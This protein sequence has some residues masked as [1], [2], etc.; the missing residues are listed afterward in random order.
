MKFT[1]IV[2]GLVMVLAICV[3]SPVLAQQN[4]ATQ[5]TS[6][7]EITKTEK[8]AAMQGME[9]IDAEYFYDAKEKRDRYNAEHRV[10]TLV[11]GGVIYDVWR[12]GGPSRLNPGGG[13]RLVGYEQHSVTGRIIDKT[14][15]FQD[16]A[17][18]GIFIQRDT[19]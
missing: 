8:D 15:G 9:E 7:K 16:M 2:I 19:P 14:A 3:I 10:P 12:H 17:Q 5:D 18:R 1:I 6:T 13:F 11:G 4:T